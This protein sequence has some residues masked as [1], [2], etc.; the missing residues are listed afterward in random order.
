MFLTFGIGKPYREANV[1][2]GKSPASRI[3]KL[4]KDKNDD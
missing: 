4:S 1:L 3:L 2:K